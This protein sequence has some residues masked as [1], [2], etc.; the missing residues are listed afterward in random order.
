M[1]CGPGEPET[2]A[3]LEY[4]SGFPKCG[5]LA[6]PSASF[7]VFK[8]ANSAIG[9]VLDRFRR[10]KQIG[11]R[12]NCLRLRP[13]TK[14][15]HQLWNWRLFPL[16]GLIPRKSTIPD[17]PV[18]KLVRVVF[19]DQRD[20]ERPYR[21]LTA[22]VEANGPGPATPG[23]DV[24]VPSSTYKPSRHGELGLLFYLSSQ[25]PSHSLTKCGRISFFPWLLVAFP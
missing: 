8:R 22:P 9:W 16:S 3:S 18:E 7:L 13:Q 21:T 6:V 14:T 17:G 20:D 10:C 11:P 1:G 15:S 12:L 24:L 4:L 23:T 2:S 25:S 19:K 5:H